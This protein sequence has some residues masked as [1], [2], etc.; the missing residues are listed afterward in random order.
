MT[1]TLYDP[2]VENRFYS[3]EMIDI[4]FGVLLNLNRLEEDS[5]ELS[6]KVKKVILE[7]EGQLSITK[8]D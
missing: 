2:E 8:E 7:V 5:L 1:K 3:E 6:K 4:G